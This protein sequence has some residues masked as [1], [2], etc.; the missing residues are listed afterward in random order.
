MLGRVHCSRNQYFGGPRNL[1]FW[2][3]WRVLVPLGESK[4]SRYIQMNLK[5]IIIPEL[6][7]PLL[8]D[9]LIPAK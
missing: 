3:R 4:L 8:S 6:V 5:D 9:A 2:R 1:S 7:L